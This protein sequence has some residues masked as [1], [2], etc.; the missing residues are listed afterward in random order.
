MPTR[1]LDSWRHTHVFLG[2][3]HHDH[4]RRVWLIVALTVVTMVAE[5]VGGMIFGSVAVTADGWHM[6]THAAALSISGLAYL[7][8][9]RHAGNPRYTFGTGKFGELAGYTSALLLAVVSLGIVYQAIERMRAPVE[10]QFSEAMLIAV[11]GLVVNVLSAWLLAGDHGHP[12]TDHHGHGPSH[13]H[14]PGHDRAHAVDG[15]RR[16][17]FAHVVADAVTSALAIVALIGASVFGWSWIDPAVG[18][19]GALLIAIWAV[20]LMRSTSAVLL[21]VMPSEAVSSA[22][23]TKLETGGDRVVDLHVWQLGPGHLGAIVSVV[24]DDPLPPDH[25]KARLAAIPHLSHVTVEVA[26]CA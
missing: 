12:D 5:I 17:A 2:A 9:R 3:H 23:R 26:R 18:L 13:A 21:D 16:A 15:N 4:E 20:G 1:S 14:V 19:L 8:A 11:L 25:Y 22:I 7:F 10:I 6:A 24:T